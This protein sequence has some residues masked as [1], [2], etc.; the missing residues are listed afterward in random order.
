VRIKYIETTPETAEA[1]KYVSNTL[2]L[3]YISFWNGVGARL[4]EH[5]E[6][7]DMDDLKQGVTADERISTWGSYVSNGAGGSCLGKDIQSLIFQLGQAGVDTSLLQSVYGINEHQKSY[8]IDRAVHEADFDFN[9]KTV[10]LLGLAFKKHTNDMRDSAALKAVDVLLGK[11]VKEIRAYDPLATEAA[12]ADWFNPEKNHL[13]ERITY[14]DTVGEA[15]KGTDATYISTDWEEFRGLAPVAVEVLTPP[16]LIID[17]RRMLSD[18]TELTEAG[19]SV[20]PVGGR[21]V[22]AESEADTVEDVPETV[23]S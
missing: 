17:G 5:L 19:F 14:H 23:Q 9:Q 16:H 21:Y 8:L 10:A 12:Q 2:L 6:N 22:P 20:L 18:Y 4:G 3:T 15:L 1:V 13:Y 11:G 7:V